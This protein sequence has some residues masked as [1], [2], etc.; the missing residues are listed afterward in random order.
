MNE[1]LYLIEKLGAAELDRRLAEAD[2]R[3]LVRQLER[4]SG[5]QPAWCRLALI[6]GRGL[7]TLGQSLQAAA[8]P[9]SQ[10]ACENC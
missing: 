2:H 3:R 6:L 7:I 9:Q 1:N 4:L 8:R 10:P 5:E